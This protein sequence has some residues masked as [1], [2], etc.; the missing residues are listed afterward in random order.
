MCL[1]ETDCTHW[2]WAPE[3]DGTCQLKQGATNAVQPHAVH[4]CGFLP[5]RFVPDEAQAFDLGL[6][7]TEDED[8]YDGMTDEEAETAL[9]VLNSFRSKRGKTRLALDARLILL[10]KELSITCRDVPLTGSMNQG[11][12]YEFFPVPP[13]SVPSRGVTG[14]VHAVSVA[15]PL[16]SSVRH[17]IEWWMS[18]VDP[19][20]G[21]KPFF[22]DEMTVVG[23]AKGS[24]GSC[25][26]GGEG[27]A[28]DA[29]VWTMLL[30]Q[31]E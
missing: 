15:A 13:A 1:A 24:A 19:K 31:T 6:S 27:S 23:F 29:I 7:L 26:D 21:T 16:D 2:T 25:H 14:Q 4:L 5:T 10:A 28:T 22:S 9:R 17:A 18:G 12:G 3:G 11:D 8:A 20:T 30:A